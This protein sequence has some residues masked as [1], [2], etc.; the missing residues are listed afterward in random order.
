M[1]SISFVY[2]L[3]RLREVQLLARVHTAGKG[4]SRY[5]DTGVPGFGGGSFPNTELLCLGSN[6]NGVPSI[7][8]G[9]PTWRWILVRKDLGVNKPTNELP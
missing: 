8:A 7:C 6:H 2:E 9:T 1:T 5:S 4:K 3:L